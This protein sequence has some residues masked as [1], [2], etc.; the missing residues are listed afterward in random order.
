M[1]CVGSIDPAKLSEND[2]VIEQEDLLF[3]LV[4][5]VPSIS[6]DE[7]DYYESLKTKL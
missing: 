5:F 1:N 7:M 2:I 6:K 3:V 4:D